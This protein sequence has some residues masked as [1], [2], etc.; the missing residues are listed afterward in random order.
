M[1][2][3]ERTRALLVS[4]LG[5]RIEDLSADARALKNLVMDLEKARD[6]INAGLDAL[7]RQVK[8]FENHERGTGGE[9][10]IEKIEAD[11]A[12]GEVELRNVEEGI[13]QARQALS[14]ALK[15]DKGG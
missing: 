11:I 2:I 5:P 13:A 6:D 7:Q 1:G 4:R 15:R 12:E 14:D 8:Y 9:V 3:L 10:N